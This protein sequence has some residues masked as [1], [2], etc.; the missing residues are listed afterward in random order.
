MDTTISY[1]QP[2]SIFKWIF[3]FLFLLVGFLGIISLSLF[4]LIPFAFAYVLLKSEGTEVDLEA[5]TYRKTTA[6]FGLKFGKWQ[7]MDNPAYISVFNTT[8]NITVRVVTAEATNSRA[9]IKLN[10]FFENNRQVT[11]YNTED[12]RHAFDVASHIAD[13]LMI[14]LLDATEKGNFKWVDK[15]QYRTSGEILH[16]D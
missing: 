15:V 8:E 3:G 4:G 10:L 1:Q 9:I 12:V 5:K 6:L 13:A 2:I 11:I 14:D 7:P 16:V